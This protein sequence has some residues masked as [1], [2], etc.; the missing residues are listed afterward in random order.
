LRR[1]WSRNPTPF[2]DELR[3]LSIVALI[4]VGLPSAS[5]VAQTDP[6]LIQEWYAQGNQ[7]LDQGLYASAR[8]E[9]QK[10]LDAISPQ[11]RPATLQLMA[12]AYFLQGH[13]EAAI[14]TLKRAVLLA[15][16]SDVTRQLL[17]LT[18]ENEGRGEEARKWLARLDSDGP[19]ELANELGAEPPTDEL[20]LHRRTANHKAPTP[21]APHAVGAFRTTFTERSPPSSPGMYQERFHMTREGMV[22]S[23]PAEG[24]Y[25]LVTE[26]F[27][28]FVPETYAPD[29]PAGLLVWISPASS[30]GLARE[31]N[32]AALADHNMIWIGANNSGN[33]RWHW[34]RTGLA[35]DAAHNMK[36]LYNI[37][38]ERVYV[39]G[40]S[41]GGRVASAL[42]ILYPEVFHGGAFFFGS[43]YFRKVPVPNQEGKF[44][45]AGFPPPPDQDLDDLKSRHRFVLVTGEHDFNRDETRANYEMFTRE[46]FEHV[47][48]F[49]IPG[50]D[51]GFG[52]EGEWLARVIEAL[53]RPPSGD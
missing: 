53:D 16:Q 44:W 21:L 7:Y 1:Y 15:P 51:H 20:Q 12:R 11:Q 33:D 30:G 24:Q 13:M 18:M 25:D 28:V 35:L 23:D 4:A 45:R 2:K 29:K 31:E 9:Y 38:P 40:Y 3:R 6:A 48:Y 39:A 32:L 42:A 41:G 10:V 27:E 36:K 43:N 47:A 8:R 37:D 50:A 5:L 46:G 49:E 14:I 34:Y 22:Q 26:S 19:G 17:V 52:L